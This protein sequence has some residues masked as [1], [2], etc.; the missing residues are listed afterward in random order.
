M[1]KKNIDEHVYQRIVWDITGSVKISNRIIELLSLFH[2]L[3]GNDPAR[4]N[5]LC[6]VKQR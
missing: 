6:K 3:N 1:V 5:I 4:N 2:Y